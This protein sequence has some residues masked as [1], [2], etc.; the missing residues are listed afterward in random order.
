MRLH[1]TLLL[2]LMGLSWAGPTQAQVIKSPADVLPSNTLAYVELRQPGALAQE[3]AALFQRTALANVPD[4]LTKL[5]GRTGTMSR[6]DMEG[7]AVFGAML[8]PEALRE[9]GRIQGAAVALTG[10]GKDKD[11]PEF[12]AI[13]LPG[14]S[15]APGF[16]MRMFLASY[17]NSYM[18][19]DGKNRTEVRTSFEPVGEVEGVRMY[20]EVRQRIRDDGTKPEVRESGPA[21][22]MMDSALLVGAPDA[23][24][25]VIRR[26]K[27]KSDE[28]S[29]ASVETYQEASRQIGNEPGLFAYGHPP[30]VIA[31]IEKA[32]ISR[33]DYG[34]LKVIEEVVNPKAI[35]S[36]AAGLTLSKGTISYRAQYRL[37]PDEKSPLLGLLPPTPIKTDLLHF[38]PGDAMLCAALSNGEGEK[39]WERLVE[40]ADKIAESTGG[41]DVPSKH[42]AEVEQALGIK[43]GKDVLGKISDVAVCMAGLGYLRKLAAER[44][45]GHGPGVLV[46]QVTGEDAAENLAKEVLPKVVGLITHQADLKP[47]EKEVE[48]QR[49]YTLAVGD[50]VAVCFGRQGA[51][52]VLGPHP[53][54]VAMSLNSGAKKGGL[55]TD[56]KAA[57]GLKRLEEPVALAMFKPVGLG[58]FFWIRELR[59][60]PQP[61]AAPAKG[62]AR[63]G[64]SGA[65]PAAAEG[66]PKEFLEMLQKDEPFMIGISRKPDRIQIEAHYTGLRTMVPMLI[67]MLMMQT[68]GESRPAVKSKAAPTPPKPPEK[69]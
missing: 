51:T 54:L 29:L 27:G 41:Q 5:R 20:R 40:L 13:V 55:G 10:I 67:D 28:P 66:P 2:T 47:T 53:G 49:I 12:V 14:E 18:N 16:G 68:L 38:V 22:A 23:V 9:A 50:E 42:I 56:E 34:R 15:N 11:M 21:I 43:I 69:P 31:A 44:K 32:G 62:P 57:A 52:L 58:G 33:N 48:G 4:S 65:E 25:D 37:N 61:S 17:R 64:G 30:G 1:R 6:G 35:R 45:P 26:A 3:I 24:K 8:S 60:E 36:V 19:F 46:I 7:L 59:M 63:L 39:R